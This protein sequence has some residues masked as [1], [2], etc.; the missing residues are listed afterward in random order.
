MNDAITNYNFLSVWCRPAQINFG[1]VTIPDNLM[2]PDG[3]A[4]IPTLPPVQECP[5]V[6]EGVREVYVP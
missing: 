3:T 1:A 4:E 6:R 2:V 5:V